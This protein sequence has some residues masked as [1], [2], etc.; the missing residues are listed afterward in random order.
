MKLHAWLAGVLLA[1][2]GL[3]ARAADAAPGGYLFAHMTHA[4]YGVLH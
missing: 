1:V 3:T 4:R 2:T